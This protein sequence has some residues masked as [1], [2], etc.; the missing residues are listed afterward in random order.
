[1]AGDSWCKQLK[2]RLYF[3][4]EKLTLVLEFRG[5]DMFCTNFYLVFVSVVL[6]CV[7]VCAV[8]AAN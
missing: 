8:C 7:L 6:V 3:Q 2:T 4:P 5:S 1:M